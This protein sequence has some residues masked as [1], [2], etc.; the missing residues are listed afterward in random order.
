MSGTIQ[1]NVCTSSR[2]FLYLI[3]F[4]IFL[5]MYYIFRLS[6]LIGN[7]CFIFPF[8]CSTNFYLTW[9]LGTT[10]A[11]TINWHYRN[12]LQ[13]LLPI[14]LY[15]WQFKK[16]TAKREKNPVL[17]IYKI[18]VKEISNWLFITNFVLN[19]AITM[20]RKSESLYLPV[21]ILGRN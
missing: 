2:F 20:C 6:F 5:N 1:I 7:F 14:F 12:I 9:P 4:H 11:K 13:T 17:I 16:K 21:N 18:K 8:I 10:W 19:F 3:I 15:S